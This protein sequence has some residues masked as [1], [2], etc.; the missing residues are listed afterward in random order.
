MNKFERQTHSQQGNEETADETFHDVDC[1]QNYGIVSYFLFFVLTVFLLR[2]R[3]G[4]KF[5]P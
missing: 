2:V 5:I 3:Y 4:K 1:L